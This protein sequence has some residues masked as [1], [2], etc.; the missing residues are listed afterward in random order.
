MHADASSRSNNFDALR[1]VA[2]LLVIW[3]HQFA[4]M[5]RPVPLMWNNEPGAVGVVLF[6][7]I[8]GY[9]VTIS[10][11]ADPHL[12]RFAAR[13]ALRIWPG[14]VAAVLFCFA[15]LGPLVSSLPARDYWSSPLARGY[16]ANLWLDTRYAL[17][18]VFDSNPFPSSVNG[19]LW[20]I[21][22]EVTCYVALA[23][24]GVVGL[25]RRRFFPP[26]V[27][28]MLAAA[29]EW[30]YNVSVGQ[31]M[32]SWSP[33]LQYA[34]MFALGASLA[35][36]RAAWLPRRLQTAVVL[37]VLLLLVHLVGPSV[38]GGQVPLLII[39]TIG[40]IWGTASTPVVH[41]VG[42]WGDFS[43]GL[44]I[45]AFPVQQFVVWAFSNRIGFA[46]AL[47]LSVVGALLLAVLS[48][49]WLEKT[50]LVLKPPRGGFAA[51]ARAL[52]RAGASTPP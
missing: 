46:A 39:A 45:Y 40:V 26:L 36:W 37:V 8:S 35:C 6:F 49:H 24:L 47:G 42:R 9:L 29:L 32:P 7:A 2:A 21:P 12:W 25:L 14:L 27:L 44:Y 10:W 18:G 48:W 43:Y 31:P 1:L 51:K 38:I 4:I 16:L 13:R 23:A 20:T 41:R 30:R 5:G 17:P 15:V 33:L 19:P 50:A 22:L 34:I 11:L 3:G 52:G 28:L